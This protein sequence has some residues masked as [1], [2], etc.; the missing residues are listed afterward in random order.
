M[1][2]DVQKIGF[3]G[4]RKTRYPGI[5]VDA[6]APPPWIAVKCAWTLPALEMN[7]LQLIPGDALIEF[8]SPAHPYNVFRV[9][10]PD[11]AVRG[12]YANVT[13]PT[14]VHGN[15]LDWHDLWLD[16]IVLPDGSFVVRDQ[17]ELEESGLAAVDPELHAAIVASC[18]ELVG[19]AVSRLFPFNHP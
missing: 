13:Y 7:G 17:D 8:F 14:V 1:P 11:G 2:V 18:E 19:L 12:W 6:G 10:A 9:H 16:L 4:E 5:V 15:E 3:S